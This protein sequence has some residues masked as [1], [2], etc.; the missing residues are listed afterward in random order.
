MLKKKGAQTLAIK[1]VGEICPAA[2]SKITALAE[3]CT[4]AISRI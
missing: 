2:I 4:A 3:L 1:T